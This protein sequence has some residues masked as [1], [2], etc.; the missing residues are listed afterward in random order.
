VELEWQEGDSL[1]DDHQQ[2]RHDA[3]CERVRR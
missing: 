2:E 1:V 3:L